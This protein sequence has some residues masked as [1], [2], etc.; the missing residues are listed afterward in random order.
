[1]TPEEKETQRKA[2]HAHR[3]N[4]QVTLDKLHAQPTYVRGEKVE[5][6]G[7]TISNIDGKDQIVNAYTIGELRPGQLIY[8]EKEVSFDPPKPKA[9]HAAPATTTLP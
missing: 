3:K 1:M 5:P 9:P 7:W 2:I 8:S 6:D 4:L